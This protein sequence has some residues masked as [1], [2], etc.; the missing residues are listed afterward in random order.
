TEPDE[1]DIVDDFFGASAR[2]D[3]VEYRNDSNLMGYTSDD[4]ATFLWTA[5]YS[6][7]FNLSPTNDRM[8]ALTFGNE[9]GDDE[10]RIALGADDNNVYLYGEFDDDELVNVDLDAPDELRV[11]ET[12]QATLNATYGNGSVINVSEDAT[13]TSSNEDVL[14]VDS[15]GG[16][17]AKAAGSATIT[18]EFEGEEDSASVEVLPNGFEIQILSEA[19]SQDILAGDNMSIWARVINH[20][21]S[22]ETETLTFNVSDTTEDTTDVTVDG[23]SDKLVNFENETTDD[24]VNGDTQVEVAGDADNDTHN[25]T[26]WANDTGFQVTI[27]EDNSTKEVEID[28]RARIRVKIVNPRDSDQVEEVRIRINGTVHQDQTKTVYLDANGTEDDSVTLD[29]ES[30]LMTSADVGDKL[31]TIEAEFGTDSMTYEVTDPDE[32][33]PSEPPIEDEVD[34]PIVDMDYSDKYLFVAAWDDGWYLFNRSDYDVIHHFEDQPSAD[35]ASTAS[36]HPDE[37]ILAGGTQ[38]DNL[39]VWNASSGSTTQEIDFPL[40]AIEATSWS[41]EGDWFALTQRPGITHVLNLTEDDYDV[42]H[43]IDLEDE[44]GISRDHAWFPDTDEDNGA[45]AVGLDDDYLIYVLDDGSWFQFIRDDLE[46]NLNTGDH[47]AMDWAQP[48]HAGDFGF[49]AVATDDDD[50]DNDATLQQVIV[51]DFG[52][53][54]GTQDTER[55]VLGTF[56]HD[57]AGD[58]AFGPRGNRLVY[59]AWGEEWGNSVVI[60]NTLNMEIDDEFFGPSNV[61][62]AVDIGN[63]SSAVDDPVTI[64]AGDDDGI[65]WRWIDPDPTGP[66]EVDIRELPTQLEIN[67][68]YQAEAW[69]TYANGSVQNETT[70]VTWSSSDEDLLTVD[71]DGVV[72]TANDSGTVDVTAEFEGVSDTQTVGINLVP[73]RAAFDFNQSSVAVNGT[74]SYT[75]EFEWS[76][77]TV[78]D[79]TD[80]YA[81]PSRPY[82]QV[83][84]NGELVDVSTDEFQEGGLHWKRDEAVIEALEVGVN[85]IQIRV[86]YEDPDGNPQ[87]FEGEEQE[88]RVRPETAWGFWPDLELV[89]RITLILSS[90]SLWWIIAATAV[91]AMV[92]YVATPFVGL[93]AMGIVL[94]TG[95]VAGFGVPFILS[96]SVMLSVLGYAG[97][98]I[99]GG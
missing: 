54:L 84:V 90:P 50:M 79:I 2:V 76:D 69:V 9:T 63:E 19:S 39:F 41:P 22:E 58:V 49:L 62:R 80:D 18:A 47:M 23:D 81:G 93:A 85:T 24:M 14:D 89:D 46:S 61:T 52:S 17:T 26:V 82:W 73:I 25:V 77:G 88:L 6:E 55:H 28:E 68:T 70:E 59:T 40:H 8:R 71:D 51:F 10:A 45:L 67:E 44:D 34:G 35:R 60:A 64:A 11:D 29:F 7:A 92:T 98:R 43:V 74:V 3:A 65:I 38:E 72:D 32:Q 31:A 75:A 33:F 66:I 78:E 97:Y 86:R 21:E 96:I 1:Y 30:P 5:A 95:S 56:R 20:N 27:D 94:L 37:D 57:W 16:L 13:W 83:Y 36:I 48:D 12:G 53:G 4:T 87:W 99:L 42:E 15:S 91:A